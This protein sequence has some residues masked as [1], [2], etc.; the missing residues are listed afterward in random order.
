MVALKFPATA[1]TEVACGIVG[2]V[3]RLQLR[4]IGLT[5]AQLA[6]GVIRE[7]SHPALFARHALH[8]VARAVV[9]ATVQGAVGGICVR[10][11][12]GAS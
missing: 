10:F 8:F 12:L 6:T 4:V 1:A 5:T 7:V 9:V 2:E 11:F 3:F